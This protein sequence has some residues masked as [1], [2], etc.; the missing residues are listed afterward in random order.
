M[1]INCQW[2][3][4][5]DERIEIEKGKTQELNFKYMLTGVSC[6]LPLNPLCLEVIDRTTQEGKYTTE[7]D[8]AFGCVLIFISAVRRL[9]EI[10]YVFP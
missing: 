9:K 6:I 2:A 5:V 10:S 7:A 4:K 3:S 1:G 8:V